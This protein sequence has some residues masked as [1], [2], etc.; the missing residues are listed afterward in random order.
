MR[1]VRKTVVIL[2]AVAGVLALAAPAFAHEEI[3]PK[4]FPTGTPTFF[5]LSAA[6]EKGVDLTKI[7]FTAPK[8]TN[9]GEATHSPA[10]WT[11]NR[12]DTVI[13]WTG[14]AVKPTQFDQWGYEIEGADQPGTL[15]YKVTL[16]FSDG[17]SDDVNVQTTAVAPGTTATTVAGGGAVTTAVTSGGTTATTEAK[18]SGGSAA[19]TRANIAL[20][21]GAVALVAA[22]IALALAAR[23]RGGTD[24]AAPAAAGGGQKQDW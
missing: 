20:V 1:A 19:R 3:N 17:S 4:Q 22:I 5:T 18:S 23:K 8:G 16:G 15:T 9:F 6:N 11:V 10:G 7:T 12:T 13:T 14:G 2:A 21:L 24:A